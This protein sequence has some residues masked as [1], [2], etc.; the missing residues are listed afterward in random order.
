MTLIQTLLTPE[1]VIQVSDRRLSAGGEIRDDTYNKAIS[2]CGMAIVGFTGGFAHVDYRLT[3]PLTNWI[4]GVLASERTVKSGVDALEVGMLQLVSKL[5]KWRKYRDRRLTITVAGIA[6]DAGTAFF[7]GL[8]NFE[9]GRQIITN[10]NLVEVFRWGYEV[11][12][13]GTQTVYTTAGADLGGSFNRRKEGQKLAKIA[14]M[15]GINN[16]AR[17]MVELQRRVAKVEK[18]KGTNTV[19]E[20]AMVVSV[21]ANLQRSHMILMSSTDSDA[22]QGGEPNFSFVK[23]G[24]FSRERFAPLIACNG[25]VSTIFAK[26]DGDNQTIEFQRINPPT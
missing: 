6:P 15:G 2:W 24:S 8:S 23:S 7:R 25:I 10:P 9:D 3:E 11:P 18:A 14:Q 16:A 1:F 17:Y 21:P 22:I 5:S 26:G 13:G 12:L 20:D 19:G 4:A